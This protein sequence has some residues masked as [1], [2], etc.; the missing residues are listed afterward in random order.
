M[1]TTRLY[2]GRFEGVLRTAQ[3]RGGS[4]NLRKEEVPPVPFLSP[5]LLHPLPLTLEIGPLI[6]A[7]GLWERF[8]IPSGVRGSPDRKRIWCTL[9]LPESHWWQSFWIFWVP[10][11]Q[12]DDRN[13]ALA[14]MTVSDGVSRSPKGGGT[15]SPPINPPLQPASF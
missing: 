7:R 15:G 8:M 6:P 5:S 3:P 2:V 11:L 12:Q 1:T 13:L 10:F 4:R 14:N 9:K